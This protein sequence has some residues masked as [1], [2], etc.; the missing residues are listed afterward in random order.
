MDTAADDLDR[1]YHDAVELADRARGWFDGPGR[2]WRAGLPVAMQAAVATE[3]LATTARLMAAM[4]WL[5]DP[6]HTIN[7]PKP[8]VADAGAAPAGDGPLAGT[9]GGEI[10]LAS[11]QLVARLAALAPAA[12]APGMET[13]IWHS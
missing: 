5:L 13:S 9:P 4:A 3:S 2:A 11:Q 7:A 12:P 1:L 8:F 10:A 6:A